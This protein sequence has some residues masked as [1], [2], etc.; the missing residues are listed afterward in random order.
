MKELDRMEK[1]WAAMN[2]DY[3]THDEGMELLQVFQK[4]IEQIGAKM[5]QDV[6]N[7]QN[8]FGTQN[9]ESV[10]QLQTYYGDWMRKMQAMYAECE[11]KIESE[12]ALLRSDVQND[13][14]NI[15]DAVAAFRVIQGPPGNPG[16]PG[17]PGQPGKDGSP[18]TPDEV[19]DK[20]NLGKPLIKKERVEGLL[21]I[22][23]MSKANST[24]NPAMGPS[25]SDLR[26]IRQTISTLQ[27]QVTRETGV[28]INYIIDG[29]GSAITTGVKGY[30]EIP[31]AMT[32]TGWDIFADQTG[33]IVVDVKK[34]TYANFPPTTSIAGSELPTLVS[35]QKNQ[36][37]SLSTWSIGLSVGDV[38]S[39]TVNSVATVTRITVS[40]IGTKN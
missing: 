24:F 32:I 39:F 22:E 12:S 26:D 28:S 16:D 21:D 30:V 5:S 14:K 8:D 9:K 40:I 37:L 36:N 2:A 11:A 3:M 1:T 38:I 23:R 15:K 31:Y 18:D 35:A 17:T 7:A 25:F 34:D 19:T 6:S 10:K 33:S 20:V 29:G 27:T 13:I 4:V